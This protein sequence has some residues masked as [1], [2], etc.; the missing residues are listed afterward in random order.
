MS[1]HKVTVAIAADHAGFALKRHLA[2]WLHAQGH[3]VV[4][5]GTDSDS[6]V[7]YPPFCAAAARAVVQGRAAL[8]VVLGGSG[9]G[10]QIAANKVA[11]ARAALCHDEWMAE[12]ARRH[13]DANVLAMGARVVA[14]ERA[15]RI[16]DTFLATPFD[17]GHH[18]HRIELIAEIEREE[19]HSH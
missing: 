17:G 2:V 19:Y 1:G 5:L 10:E 9:Q 15:Q 4:D 3:E 13:N 8:G 11:G 7:D 6:P 18:T 16:L 12:M 14:R